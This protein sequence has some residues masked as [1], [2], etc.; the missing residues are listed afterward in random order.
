MI[1]GKPEVE[2]LWITPDAEKI[3]ERCGRL[4]HKTEDRIDDSSYIEFIRMIKRL[5]HESVLEHASASFFL[6]GV[7]R[8]LTHQL[9]RHRIASY[10]EKSLRY[11]TE[12]GYMCSLPESIKSSKEALACYEY[13]MGACE[14]MY[15]TMV[16]GGIPR[17]DAR[18][19]LNHNGLTEIVV[20][21]NFRSWLHF[22]RERLNPRA[23]WEIR[24]VAEQI[25]KELSHYASIVFEDIGG[26]N[27]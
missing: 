6:S 17:E 5:G 20:T 25:F 9:V 12:D 2:M 22:L 15:K 24:E 7:S 3:I 16:K 10:T 18:G 13:A 27:D 1:F 11:V 14:N 21:M 19:V 8:A 4:S 26:C 23:Q